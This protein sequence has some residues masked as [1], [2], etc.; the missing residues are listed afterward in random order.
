MALKTFNVH[1]N[2]YTFVKKYLKLYIGIFYNMDTPF[3][4][5]VT[6]VLYP[7]AST[8]E[9]TIV[10]KN[11]NVVVV[12]N[13]N[14][15]VSSIDLNKL[16]SSQV[17]S[18]IVTFSSFLENVKNGVDAEYMWTNSNGN[19]LMCFK[20]ATS[21]FESLSN[22]MYMGSQIKLDLSDE[23]FKNHVLLEL[24]KLLLL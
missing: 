7:G 1:N 11:N 17:N 3:E 16:Y 8:S 24:N 5:T 9:H 13:L 19:D 22:F 20:A 15:F 6:T 21:T 12:Q 14:K 23:V 4:F 2:N 10:L 18:K